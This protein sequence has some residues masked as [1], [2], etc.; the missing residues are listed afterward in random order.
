MEATKDYTGERFGKLVVLQRTRQSGQAKWW[1]RWECV[2]DCGKKFS[3]P[4]SAILRSKTP[5]CGCARRTA[6]SIVGE[7][8]EMLKVVR[9]V[10][11]DG[12]RKTLL[13][14]IC[15]CGNVKLTEASKLTSGDLKSCGCW[16]SVH[17]NRVVDLAGRRYG[18]LTVVK[19]DGWN[20]WFCL[21][22]CGKLKSIASSNVKRRKSCGCV[23][24]SKSQSKLVGRKINYVRIVELGGYDQKGQTFL[25]RCR[26]FC[27]RVFLTRTT[28]LLGNKAIESCGCLQHT[29]LAFYRSLEVQR[30]LNKISNI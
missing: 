19:R 29:K 23:R 1:K 5:S 11:G 21:C 14:C 16:K 7:R 20:R 22:D 25:W 18:S 10:V 8:Y 3:L 15:D 26:C 28:S 12:R 24:L 2:C 30:G 6:E 27:G 9:V 4:E 17:P 13:E